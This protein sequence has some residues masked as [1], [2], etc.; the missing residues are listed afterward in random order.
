[1][2]DAKE[3]EIEN[4]LMKRKPETIQAA[5]C[6]FR[7]N[8]FLLSFVEASVKSGLVGKY[9]AKKIL[10]NLNDYET[11]VKSFNKLFF[12]AEVPELGK[13]KPSKDIIFS[14][15]I[16]FKILKKKIK[17]LSQKSVLKNSTDKVISI[18]LETSGLLEIMYK[19]NIDILQKDFLYVYN[20]KFMDDVYIIINDINKLI[21]E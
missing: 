8:S 7:L 17:T 3:K 20:S 11:K 13:E 19:K 9:D 2:R 21:I 12:C 6:L 18:A 4:E 5:I 10:E 1:M 16:T 14:I 15:E